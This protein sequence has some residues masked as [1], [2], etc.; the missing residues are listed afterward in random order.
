MIR[1][2]TAFALAFLALSPARAAE[3]RGAER[4]TV[5]GIV[6]DSL[7]HRPLVGATVMV[8]PGGQS[9]MTDD[10]GRFTVIAPERITRVTVFHFTLDKT[11]IG[12]VSENVTPGAGQRLVLATPSA[13]TAW[14]RLCPGTT[15]TA[16]RDGVVFGTVRASDGRTRIAG[17]KIRVSW[18][19]GAPDPTTGI[20]QFDIK[21]DS[22]G[23]FYACGIPATETAYLIA[24][25]AEFASGMI[26]LAGDSLPLRKL[27]V[28]A[29]R[30]KSAAAQAATGVV[31]GFVRDAGRR[32]VADAVVDI[33]GLD[34]STKTDVNGRFRFAAVPAGSR[35]LLARAI[36]FTPTVQP[37]DVMDRPGEEVQVEVQRQVL[38][39]GVR[40]TDRLNVP[41]L[42]AEFDERKRTMFG[43]YLDS[44]AVARKTNIRNVFEGIASL[45]VTGTDQAK[46]NLFTPLLHV[47]GPCRAN[48]YVDGMRSDT[49]E[50]VTLPKD[51]VSGVEVYVRQPD[52]PAKYRPLDNACGVVLV[53]TRMAFKR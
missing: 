3:I 1:L 25:S 37:I 6:Y 35:M 40:V 34:L 39:P 50:L 13:A 45:E 2:A 43:V 16:D 9:V 21:T 27:D 18:D 30:Q 28:V 19:K 17:A 53:W 7:Q 38:L 10:A 47:S 44:S 41:I 12:S 31:S 24:Y 8:E 52:A 11:G 51:L 33:D 29:G 48:I 14:Q 42:R 26:A 23:V 5:R 15:R 4:D 20:R 32:P 49:D 46:F 36:G 22:V